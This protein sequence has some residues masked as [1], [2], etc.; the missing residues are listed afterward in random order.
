MTTLPTRPATS[1]SVG[2]RC[3][4]RAAPTLPTTPAAHL[5]RPGH[6]EAPRL[7][8]GDGHLGIW[9]ALL[10]VFPEAQEQRCWNHRILNVL[11]QLPKKAQ[12]RAKEML[13]AL[14]Y[15]GTLEE[16]FPWFLPPAK[17]LLT[18]PKISFASFLRQKSPRRAIRIG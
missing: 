12:A 13:R 4:P 6:G 17:L 11:D 8:I 14:A 15:A 1:A 2:R 9:A 18:P 7:V 10:H 16:A 5:A 3:W